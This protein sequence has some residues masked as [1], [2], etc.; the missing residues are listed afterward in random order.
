MPALPTLGCH[1]AVVLS[2]RIE[3]SVRGR[4]TSE[5]EPG[6][7]VCFDIGTSDDVTLT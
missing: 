5:L 6:D 2:G 1:L 3:L 4:P 7:V